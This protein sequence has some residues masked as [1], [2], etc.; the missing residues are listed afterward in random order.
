MDLRNLDETWEANGNE[1]IDR[2]VEEMIRARK[3]GIVGFRSSHSIAA[4]LAFFLGQVR[5]GC[6]LLDIGL[7][8]L[9][10]Q[11]I[12]YGSEDLL[13]VISFPR[14]ASRTLHILKYGQNAGCKIIVITDSP[15]SPI[16]Q[17]ADLAWPGINLPPIS[18]PSPERLR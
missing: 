16:G 4:L 2:A 11:F 1:V 6:E 9:P 15:V 8:N 13:V 5:K 3:V 7:G 17:T 14:Y 18:I 12:D 10:N